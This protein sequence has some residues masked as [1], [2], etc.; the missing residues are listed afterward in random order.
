MWRL[1]LTVVVALALAAP[2]GAATVRGDPVFGLVFEAAPGEMNDVQ[3]SYGS[4]IYVVEDSG[5][6]LSAGNGDCVIITAHEAHCTPS[7][8]WVQVNMSL[9]DEDDTAALVSVPENSVVNINLHGGPGD[10][11]VTSSAKW[12]VTMVGEDG[13]DSLVLAPFTGSASFSGGNGNDFFKGAG[14]VDSFSGGDGNDTV[15]PSLNDD[16]HGGAGSDTL[17]LSASGL[18]QTVDLT[19]GSISGATIDD[20]FENVLAGSGDDVLRGNASANLL[21]GGGGDDLLDGRFG[22]D[23]FAGGDGFDV[24]D[25]S[26]RTSGIVAR[27]NGTPESGNTDDGPSG[28]RDEIDP[29]VEGVFGGDGPDT[30]VGNAADNLFNGGFGADGFVGGP[31][32]DAVDY[33]DRT[34][35]VFV[36]LD[37]TPTSGNADDGPNPG[38]DIVDGSMEDIFGGDGDDT[39]IG[40]SADNFLDG[41]FGADVLFGGSGN[42]LAD[43]SQR[44]DGVTILL[45]DTPRSGNDDDGPPGARDRLNGIEDALGGD[46]DDSIVGNG[47]T[48]ILLGGFG[49]D[50]IDGSLAPD[51]IEGGSGNDHLASRDGS[52]DSV[53]CGA[54]ADGA[55]VERIDVVAP[56]CET[57]DQGVPAVSAA[58][59]RDVTRVSARLSA[60][61]HP[62][63]VATSAYFELGPTTAYGTR[64]TT[65]SLPA[66]NADVAVALEITGLVPGTTYHVRVVAQNAYG[67]AAGPDAAFTTVAQPPP[68]PPPPIRCR[69]PNVKGKTLRAARRSLVSRHCAV[70]RI[71]RRYSRTIPRNRVVTQSRRPGATLPKRTAVNLVVSRGKKPQTRPRPR[72]AHRGR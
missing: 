40:N 50:T 64:S 51:R 18:G 26:D 4:G 43:Y 39:L 27:L 20:T 54:D 9:D 46:G 10:D 33:S 21:S 31:G 13:D 45:D 58:T 3:L 36:V 35:A 56:D 6:N 70:G 7:G 69:V 32:F 66:G 62:N 12:G 52:V 24:A 68:P 19:G 2:A 30:F 5:A 34:A 23:A 65:V 8:M 1:L 67:A 16:L 38:R 53:F 48:N 49:D 37:G 14:F 11:V 29:D 47:L 41:G 57:I 28:S 63:R 55:S 60:S 59:V 71:V 15:V 72:S 22:A 61:V 25:F 42:D 17:D 44:I